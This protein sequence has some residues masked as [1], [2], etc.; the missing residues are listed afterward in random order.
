MAPGHQGWTICAGHVGM[1]TQQHSTLRRSLR[2]GPCRHPPAIRISGGEMM[3]AQ[4]PPHLPEVM[5]F[6]LAAVGIAGVVGPWLPSESRVA[7]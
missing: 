3:T 1:L 6:D 7:R 2:Q 5:S 4:S